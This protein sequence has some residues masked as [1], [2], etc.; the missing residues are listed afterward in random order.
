[1][2]FVLYSVIASVY[3]MV[4]YLAIVIKREFYLFLMIGCFVFGA[5]IGWWYQSWEIGLIVAIVLSLI[6][7]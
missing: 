1:M 3:I 2:D 4:V 6:F 7:Y 5:V